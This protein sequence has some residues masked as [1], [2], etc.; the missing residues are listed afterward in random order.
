M[1]S[2]RLNVLGKQFATHYSMRVRAR[3]GEGVKE[4]GV[5]NI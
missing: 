1:L 5:N 3:A 4:S 2:R